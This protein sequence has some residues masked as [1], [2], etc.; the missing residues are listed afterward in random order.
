LSKEESWDRP[1]NQ[2][3]KTTTAIIHAARKGHCEIVDLLRDAG[4]TKNKWWKG[5]QAKDYVAESG[6]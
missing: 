6:C 4:Y 5:K 3:G 1:I 2:D